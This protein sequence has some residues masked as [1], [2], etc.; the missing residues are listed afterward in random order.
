VENVFEFIEQPYLNPTFKELIVSPQFMRKKIMSLLKTEIENAKKGLP[1][2]IYCKINHV[3]DEKIIEKLYEA[4]N[5]GV[6]LNCW[7]AVIARW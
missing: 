7:F 4:S 6:Q 1:A 3:V 2:Y 5:A